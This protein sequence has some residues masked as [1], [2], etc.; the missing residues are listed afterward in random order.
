MNT[1]IYIAI[2]I[3]IYSSLAFL[4]NKYISRYNTLLLIT[5]YFLLLWV[6]AEAFNQIHM[7]LRD[8]GIYIELGHASITGILI[9]AGFYSIGFLI[10]IVH[11]IKKIKT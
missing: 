11:Y 8:K 2:Q 1:F 5:G 4:F 7:L 3:I 9:L 6:I 10:I